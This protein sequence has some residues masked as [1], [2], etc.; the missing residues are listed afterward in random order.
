MRNHPPLLIITTT[1]AA[2]AVTL[3]AANVAAS[4]QTSEPQLQRSVPAAGATGVPLNTAFV[5]FA[6]H[7]PEKATLDGV[8]LTRDDKT[9][10]A[11]QALDAETT[12]EL[13]LR[14][15]Q[16]EMFPDGQVI[17]QSF[18]TGTGSAPGAPP[19][20]P[21]IVQD[22]DA[23]P[24]GGYDSWDA[25]QSYAGSVGC[26][27]SN[28]PVWVR[29]ETQPSSAVGWIIRAT[30]SHPEFDSLWPATCSTE[31]IWRGYATNDC[32][33]ITAIDST[34]RLSEPAEYCVQ[35]VELHPRGHQQS[36]DVGT[37]SGSD[38][39]EPEDELSS[40]SAASG[41]ATSPLWFALFALIVLRRRELLAAR[42]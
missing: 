1:I 6:T 23:T 14:F 16:T 20:K 22:Q 13:T 39:G 32:F 37:N 5:F 17:T 38:A 19:P 25:C 10:S 35:N 24:P 9:W 7:Q 40:C 28:D 11:S 34:G 12:Y 36:A 18:T 3:T 8:P 31:I 29:F 27:D 15:A 42:D 33:E 41:S 2:M 4:C 26:P 21:T 30:D